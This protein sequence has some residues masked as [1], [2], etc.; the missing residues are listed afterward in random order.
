MITLDSI[1]KVMRDKTYITV[2]KNGHVV[3]AGYLENVDP[4]FRRKFGGDK[5]V[6]MRALPDDHYMIQIVDAW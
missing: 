3:F 2:F 1:L 6:H 4:K 5:I